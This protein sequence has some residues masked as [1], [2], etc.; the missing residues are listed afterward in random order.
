MLIFPPPLVNFM[1]ASA[2]HAGFG[3][4]LNLPQNRPKL[5]QC[6]V[7]EVFASHSIPLPG[8]SRSSI[9]VRKKLYYLLANSLHGDE[10]K[11]SR[12][13]EALEE[14]DLKTAF[15][16]DK[17]YDP[18]METRRGSP[19]LSVPETLSSLSDFLPTC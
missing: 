11:K 3:T 14:L 12:K 8:G 13:V 10:G 9:L 15:T 4:S 7:E 16:S 17:A 6:H 1:A 18:L 5:S 19:Q 2:L